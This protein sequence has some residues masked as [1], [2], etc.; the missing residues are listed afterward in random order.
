MPRVPLDEMLERIAQRRANRRT[1]LGGGLA[2][3]LAL[4]GVGLAHAQDATPEAADDSTNPMYLFVQLAEG[5]TWTQSEDDPEI[6][7][8]TLSGISSQTVYFS[9]RPERIVGTTDTAQFLENLGFT[10]IN[11][12]NAAAVVRTP[13]GERDVLVV[14]GS[15][16]STPAR[17]AR[18]PRPHYVSR[19]NS[20]RLS[21]RQSGLLVRRGGRPRAPVTIR[22]GDPLHRR[23]SRHELLRSISTRRVGRAGHGIPNPGRFQV[24]RIQRATTMTS[25]CATRARTPGKSSMTFAMTAIQPATATAGP[26]K[27]SCVPGVP[28]SLQIDGRKVLPSRR[29]KRHIDRAFDAVGPFRHPAEQMAVRYEG[30]RNPLPGIAPDHATGRPLVPEALAEAIP[31]SDE[32]SLMM[33]PIPQG[34][35]GETGSCRGSMMEKPTV[36]SVIIAACAA[37]E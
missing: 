25:G 35:M 12:P 29:R 7:E 8:L 27:P 11:P 21:R 17:L 20:G 16:P 10:P 34:D 31:E 14:R 2:S 18:M 28:H 32:P 3:A 4:T 9:D 22:P 19:P 5:G 15:T 13:E 26:A 33:N 36:W 23:L 6:Y 24:A 37:A 30:Q 1:A